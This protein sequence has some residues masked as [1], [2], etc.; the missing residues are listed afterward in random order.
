MNYYLNTRK[1]V[2]DFGGLTSCYRL[3]NDNGFP[4]SRDAIDKWR[5]RKSLSSRNLIQMAVVA[6]ETGKRFDLYDYIEGEAF[7]ER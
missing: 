2:K 4:I 1:M 5:R 3:L 7:N 6:K